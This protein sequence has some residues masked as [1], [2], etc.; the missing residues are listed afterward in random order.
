MG[1]RFHLNEC[2]CNCSGP[3]TWRKKGGMKTVIMKPAEKKPTLKKL[4]FVTVSIE[5]QVWD[6]RVG[7]YQSSPELA[8][9]KEAVYGEHVGVL[10]WYFLTFSA[11]CTTP[12]SLQT[13]PGA[14]KCAH[15]ACTNQPLGCTW[16]GNVAAGGGQTFR[17][18]TAWQAC[19]GAPNGPGLRLHWLPPKESQLVCGGVLQ[20]Y[21]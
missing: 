14:P 17:H 13:G 19:R 1:A 5:L 9:C 11:T 10:A 21:V 7:G 8:L 4:L 20:E 2:S 18:S 3:C 12:L 16:Q 6:Y 15:C